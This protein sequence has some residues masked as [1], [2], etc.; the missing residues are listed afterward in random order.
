ME[1]RIAGTVDDQHVHPGRPKPGNGIGD[2]GDAPFSRGG[3]LEY[4]NRGHHTTSIPPLFIEIN[5]SEWRYLIRLC[6][7]EQLLGLLGQLPDPGLAG[8]P[9]VEGRSHQDM[10]DLRGDRVT[11]PVEGGQP[12][13]RIF[14][15]AGS[16]R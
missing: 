16:A 8:R 6:V 11:P 3:L 2:Q 1:R 12:K 13:C 5:R 14:S 10:G 4:S 9:A 7:A 15:S